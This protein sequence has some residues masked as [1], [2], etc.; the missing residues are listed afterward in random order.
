M[1]GRYAII[2]GKKVLASFPMLQQAV[3][4]TEAFQGLPQYN[5]A[6]MQKL[7]VVALRGGTLTVDRM[8]WWLVPHWSKE[9]ASQ[10]STFNAKG[11]TLEKSRLFGPYFKGS[12]C[13][14][15]ADAFYEWKKSVVSKKTGA[16]AGEV[17]EKHPMCIRMR[18]EQTF[19]FAGLFS[20]W[21][22]GEEGEELA[23]FT[24]ITTG[25]NEL[26]APIH[27]RMPVIL[28]EKDY[29]RWLD[30]E[31]HDTGE[32]AKLLVAHPASKMKAYRVSK[33][34]NSSKN[35]VPECIDPEAEEVAGP[36]RKRIEGG[37]RSPGS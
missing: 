6:P 14:V 22:G 24:I 27:N 30:R 11:E 7:P 3:L 16:A 37:A 33:L 25:P 34:V 31:Y 15:P 26:L 8:Q 13:L 12:R 2:D 28:T 10:F 36:P 9:P 23:T 21:K 32:L 19:M 5:A 17:T 20:V 18:S 35:N 4:A 1:C 29:D